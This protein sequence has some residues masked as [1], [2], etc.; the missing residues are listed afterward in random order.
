MAHGGA[1]VGVA[2]SDD[3]DGRILF[4]DGALPGETV[5]VEVTREGKRWRRGVALRLRRASPDRVEPPCPLADTCGG[6]D[7]Q[8]V[9]PA[10]QGR[11]KRDIV[12]D[13]LRGVLDG[14]TVGDTVGVG[15]PLGYRR[16]AKMHYIREGRELRL[17][18][19]PART[20]ELVD[21]R[22]CLVLAPALDRGLQ[23][24]RAL[25]PHLPIQGNVLGL[26]D[27][28]KVVLG[29]PGVRPEEALVAAA[30]AAVDRELVGFMLRGGRQ[31]HAVGNPWLEID[32][33]QGRT[34]VVAGPFSF[35]QAQAPGNAALVRHVVARAHPAGRRVLE[36]FAGG[37]N[38]TRG[39]SREARRV[40]TVDEDRES[41]KLLRELAE[42]WDL[43][44]NAKHGSAQRLL[45]RLARAGTRYESIV[46]DPPRKGLGEE[47]AVALSRVASGH[48][49][50][51]SCDP[52]TLARD[53]RVLVDRGLRLTDV[54]VFDLMP[55]TA[56]VEVVATL[57]V[58]EELS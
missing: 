23:R 50:Y 39:L 45:Q 44:I 30:Q 35:A 25:A 34:P 37:G 40:W 17:G 56:Q 38:F 55:M 51:V 24:I 57:R 27:R 4:V 41:V 9:R 29:L 42:R 22:S 8:Y 11:L 31:R 1:A 14:V 36:L 5:E 12:I 48:V 53:L 43:S 58:P 10:A 20:H 16:R 18:F 7:W 32:G 19:R 26:S 28:E 2:V 3:D 47:A 46:L 49:V 33:E 15:P 52:A 21:V 13:Q 6:C 54:H